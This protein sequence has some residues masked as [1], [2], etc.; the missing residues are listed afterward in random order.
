MRALETYHEAVG[1]KDPAG[2]AAL[3]LSGY[4]PDSAE[5]LIEAGV[6][7]IPLL[8]CEREAVADAARHRLEAVLFKLRRLP[9][10]HEV[11]RTV[12][13]LA[14]EV[15]RKEREGRRSMWLGFGVIGGLLLLLVVLVYAI[16]RAFRG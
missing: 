14:A 1:L 8:R 11:S 13:E 16:V 4:L 6:R 9:Q 2:Q 10:T 3:L 12:E 7:C 15:A 5:V